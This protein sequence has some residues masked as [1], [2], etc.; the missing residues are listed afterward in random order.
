MSERELHQIQKEELLSP[1]E[2]VTQEWKV[3]QANR[4]KNSLRWEVQ[5]IAIATGVA[6]LITISAINATQVIESFSK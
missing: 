1:M 4:A 6:I 5:G 3:E 2:R